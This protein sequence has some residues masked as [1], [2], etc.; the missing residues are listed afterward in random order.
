MTARTKTTPRV[1]KPRTTEAAVPPQEEPSRYGWLVPALLIAAAA[2]LFLFRLNTPQRYIYDE[3]Y[4]AYTA[5]QYVAGNADAW[6]WSTKAPSVVAPAP[7]VAYEWT[8][9]PLGKLLIA[10][11]ILAAGSGSVGWRLAS[12]LFGAL[13]VGLVYVLA[14]QLTRHILAAALAAGLLLVDG[15]YFVQ[16]RTGMVD[17]FL[18]FFLVAALLF[19]YQYLT[20]PPDKVRW[21]LLRTGCMMG[22]A[23]ATKWSAV[24]ACALIGVVALVRTY[25]L[26]KQTGV[27]RP[28]PDAVIGYREHLRWI[29][30]ALICLPIVVYLASFI[31]FF[32][33]GHTPGQLVELHRQ[34]FYYHSRLQA[35]HSYQSQ[36][37]SWPLTLRPVWYFVDRSNGEVASIYAN[38]NPVLYW[39]FLPAMAVTI[40]LLWRR[41]TAVLIVLLIGFFGQWLP[42][43]LSPRISFIYHFL[44]AVPFGCLAV[45]LV[46][47]HLWRQGNGG[48]I[49]AGGYVL[50]AV[51]AFAWLYPIYSGVYLRPSALNARFLLDS[52]R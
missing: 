11:G 8:H 15:L 24:Y 51:A 19:L 42:W 41:H 26:R 48:R 1:R 9:P 22:L 4:H 13:G 2:I 44:P 39:A 18:T 31:P 6:L 35:T 5:S 12:A 40:R 43:S 47:A 28:K 27:R 33:E 29:P 25:N 14:L 10:D 16:S 30:L 49:I 21:P 32:V 52:W 23:M 17:I 20:A 36:W 7:Q 45:G 38:G 46:L 3:V 37:W 50:L 34:M